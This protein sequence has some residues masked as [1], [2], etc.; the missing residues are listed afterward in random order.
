MAYRALD[1]RSLPGYLAS[2]PDLTARLGPA[3]S[4]WTVK[5]VGDGN[6]NLVFLV[7]G[8]MGSICVKQ[9]LPYMRLVG[10][11][12]PLPLS[13]SFF[14]HEALVEQARHTPSLVPAVHHYDRELALIVME[15][16]SPHVIM[17]KGLIAGTRYPRFARDVSEFLAANLF[18]TSD[19]AM[20]AAA[21]RARAAVFAG[22]D[23]LCKI[24][25]DLIF[26]EPY[27]DAERN[28][29]TRP[30]LDEDARRLREDG[31][32][33]CH[34]VEL[35]R[36]FLDSAE[37]LLHGDLHTG[38]IMLTATDTRVIDPEFAFYG[39][40]GFD[41]GAVLGNLFLA[42]FSQGGHANGPAYAEWILEQVGEVWR[43]FHDGFLARW[44]RGASGDGCADG[45]LDAAA[46]RRTQSQTLARVLRDSLGFA[47]AKM[48]RRIVGLAHVLDLESIEDLAIRAACER[49]ALALARR[50]VVQRETLSL[51]DAVA[52]ARNVTLTV[53]TFTG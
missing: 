23:V 40:M 36:L 18:G 15:R 28:R 39:P 37:A 43:G 4:S 14:E 25:E 3:A 7:D 51:A 53:D 45:F 13:R 49:R 27:L 24:S 19:L 16:L 2:F 48:I 11:G 8:P 21:K 47:G 50:L 29:W 31:E 10:E 52:A 1:D 6:L 30:H 33:K 20:P 22:N 32:L 12:W 46:L 5:E 26:T 44:N 9:A 35:K 17:R 34:V 41:V 42:Y 38:S